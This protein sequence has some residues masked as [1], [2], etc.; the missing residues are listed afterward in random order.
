MRERELKPD[1]Y[2]LRLVPYR[3]LPMRERELK[4]TK[5]LRL[6]AFCSSLPM[7]ERELKPPVQTGCY[8]PD[9]S[10]PMR[11][12]ELKLLFQRFSISACL[13]A[14]HA[15][16]RIETAPRDSARTKKSVAPHAGARIETF[17]V[18]ASI[19]VM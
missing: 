5:C 6:D 15:G 13:V 2:R 16:A 7:R 1:C 18:L 14:P 11:E 19:R 17:C 10:L 8:L 9:R 3:S 12:R 4:Q